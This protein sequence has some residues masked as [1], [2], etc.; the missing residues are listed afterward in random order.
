MEVRR[1]KKVS[2]ACLV[3]LLH[4]G[5]LKAKFG[6]LAKSPISQFVQVSGAAV[7]WAIGF[8]LIAP[9]ASAAVTNTG[10]TTA[11]NHSAVTG[12]LG[13]SDQLVLYN[14]TANP[15]AIA[16]GPSAT[17]VTFRAAAGGTLKPPKAL[18][19]YEVDVQGK[20]LSRECET[21][22][23]DNGEDKDR[24]AGDLVYTGTRDISNKVDSEKY[25]R[26]QDIEK[27][28]TSGIT[29]F[30]ITRYPLIAR[31]SDGKTL[32]KDP[33]SESRFFANEV[34]IRVRP[35]VLSDPGLI[36]RITSA[37]EG[38]VEGVIPSTRTYLLEIRG[39][40]SARGVLNA[41][42]KLQ[43]FEEVEE[44][45]PNYEVVEQAVPAEALAP[46]T[47]HTANCQWYN[48]HVG[49]KKAWE[50]VGG[51]STSNQVAVVEMHG[52]DDHP[53]INC[54]EGNEAKN[55]PGVGAIWPCGSSTMT[56]AQEH[57]TR[58]AGVLAAKAD[59]NGIAGVAFDAPLHSYI[60]CNGSQYHL[61]SA[62]TEAEADL[63][64]K[65]IINISGSGND[66][67]GV[68][69]ALQNAVT[70]GNLIVAAA[71]NVGVTC[72][73]D[74]NKYPAAYNQTPSLA[75]GILAVGATDINND[76]ASWDSQCSNRANWID[77]FAPGK[78]IYTTTPTDTYTHES[79]TSVAAPIVSG[80][81]AI[82]WQLN[83]TWSAENIHDKLVNRAAVLPSCTTPDLNPIRC[84]QGKR[85]INLFASLGVPSDLTLNPANP[86]VKEDCSDG[87]SVATVSA[88]DLDHT[89]PVVSPQDETLSYFFIDS[90]NNPVNTVG[91]FQ[92]NSST[93]A[94]TVTPECSLD[95]ATTTSYDV[96]VRVVDSVNLTYDE[97]FIIN[98]T[99]VDES[100]DIV[101]VLDRSGSMG[102]HVEPGDTNSAIR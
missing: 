62:I 15:P 18:C 96:K 54:E 74:D 89:E 51:G 17:T 30:G 49:I 94:I 48:E 65:S 9:S 64:P 69:T 19:L 2:R 79:G 22:L 23:F 29:T 1:G 85:L 46:C 60:Y 20:P 26:V 84:L 3:S 50:L 72:P 87:F 61:G 36:E 6:R 99:D 70:Q 86:S 14:P 71:G 28:A 98:V 66:V 31:P 40:G 21:E 4:T 24:Q 27:T 59:G 43:D 83:P 41:I 100:Y 77:I 58:V 82:L 56:V 35:G 12:K 32:V 92:I 93:G 76:L 8:V 25:Y 7:F 81:A 10:K 80:A 57:G 68:Q 37:A 5:F 102:W 75:G 34:V 52:I 33:E 13:G 95:Y 90:A 53:D 91:P 101:F 16:T 97:D 45:Y 73:S 44:A 42:P 55:C 11:V 38:T 39:D 63:G 67:S 47:T 88:S 78:N